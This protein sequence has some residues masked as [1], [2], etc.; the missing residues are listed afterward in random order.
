M[1]YEVFQKR[2]NQRINRMK[3][4][5]LRVSF[6]HDPETGKHY[7]NISDVDDASPCGNCITIV[8]NTIARNLM[9]LWGSGHR[10]IINI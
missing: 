2:I 4:V 10:A 5:K 3:G 7:T 8:G 6:S 1:S 9:V